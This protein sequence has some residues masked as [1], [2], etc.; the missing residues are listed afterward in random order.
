VPSLLGVPLYFIIKGAK[1]VDGAKAFLKYF[2]EPARLNDY[3][4]QARGR[5]TPVMPSVIKSDPWWMDPS[6]PHRHVAVRQALI[7]PKVSWFQ[8]RNPAYA[9]VNATQVW[10]QAEAD[11]TQGGHDHD[12]G[13]RQ[14]V[15]ADRD[16]LREVP[17]DVDGRGRATIGRKRRASG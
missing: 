16:D 3:L 17:G 9:E 5:W 7:T 15:Q 14:G 13:C 6:D 12:A 1:N 2:I 4:K 8:M 10:A 11:I